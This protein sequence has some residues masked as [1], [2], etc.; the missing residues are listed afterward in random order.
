M[1]EEQEC[2]ILARDCQIFQETH[3]ATVRAQIERLIQCQDDTCR[4]IEDSL[5]RDGNVLLEEIMKMTPDQIPVACLSRIL[6]KTGDYGHVVNPNLLAELILSFVDT[7]P[8]ISAL[9][10]LIN[11]E[12][13]S[14]DCAKRLLNNEHIG[15]WF[16]ETQIS[17]F[18]ELISRVEQANLACESMSQTCLELRAENETLRSQ[19]QSQQTQIE[20]LRTSIQELGTRMRTE[21]DSRMA[22]VRRENNK[23]A[24]S[25]R[26]ALAAVNGLVRQKLSTSAGLADES[27]VRQEIQRFGCVR[28]N[29]VA[30]LT[31]I[32]HPFHRYI[33]TRRSNRDL[34]DLLNPSVTDDFVLIATAQNPSVWIDIVFPQARNVQGFS[35]S[36]MFAVGRLDIVF[37]LNKSTVV[38]LEQY[39]PEG[40][41][42][43]PI[44]LCRNFDT[45]SI[46]SVRIKTD[47]PGFVC[48]QWFELFSPD[49]E[50]RDG[51]FATLFARPP[52]D[53]AHDLDVTSSTCCFTDRRTFWSTMCMRIPDPVRVIDYEWYE[54]QFPRGKVIPVRFRLCGLGDPFSLRCSNDRNL[55]LD[56]WTILFRQENDTFVDGEWECQPFPGAWRYVRVVREGVLAT[57][58]FWPTFF[59][60]DGQYIPDE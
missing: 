53:L 37:C 14:L 29:I 3:R 18:R 12:R 33:A 47:T 42:S 48:V 34:V 27:G 17:V 59:D 57:T 60:I 51:I 43:Q 45:I 8:E 2:Q 40:R 41:C 21:M 32:G 19:I 50:F 23:L 31:A 20:E 56:Q 4:L 24:E 30:A 7:R 55:P 9:M 25:T 1:A 35:I 38:R 49:M 52:E 15:E 46:D 16:D 44:E 10:Y 36:G 58:P 28:H 6:S 11:W 39:D 22:E 54:V 5:S 26:D 13:I